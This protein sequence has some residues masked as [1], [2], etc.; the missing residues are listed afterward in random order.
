MP[1]TINHQPLI[2]ALIALEIISY[3]LQGPKGPQSPLTPMR[4]L[5]PYLETWA[6]P[7]QWFWDSWPQP[8]SGASEGPIRVGIQG[9]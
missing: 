9:P 3:G 5:R 1:N 6:K 7:Y 4:V 2:A 8:C